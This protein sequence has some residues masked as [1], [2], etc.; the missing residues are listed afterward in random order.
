MV[1]SKLHQYI[2]LPN[3][4]T[5]WTYVCIKLIVNPIFQQEMIGDHPSYAKVKRVINSA[6][7]ARHAKVKAIKDRLARQHKE[8]KEKSVKY[9]WIINS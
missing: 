2:F 9:M 6:N 5:S 4:D 8:D 1:L 7:E 3:E